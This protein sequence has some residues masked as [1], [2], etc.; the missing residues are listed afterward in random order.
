[1]RAECR[2]SWWRNL[3]YIN[4]FKSGGGCIAWTWYI[5]TDMQFYIFAPLLISLLWRID[6]LPRFRTLCGASAALVLVVAASLPPL[7]LTLVNDCLLYTSDAA[8]E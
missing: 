2:A 6:R 4:N 1:M 5:A 8:D 3:A 7:I